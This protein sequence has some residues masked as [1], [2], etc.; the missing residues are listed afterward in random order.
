M[1][2]AVPDL[3][4]IERG[5]THSENDFWWALREKLPDDYYV[6][7][8][9][10]F[11]T[12]DAVQGE[13]DF[14]VF[15]RTLGMLNIECKGKGVFRD[16]N[17]QWVR[18]NPSGKLTRLTKTPTE[19]A[20]G[21]IQG[22]VDRLSGEARRLLGDFDGRF[23]M[24]FGWALAFPYAREDE[25][26]LPPGL[27]PEIVFD[28]RDVEKLAERVREAYDFYGK[29]HRRWAS[30]FSQEKLDRF[31]WDGILR[32]FT[33]EETFA[34]K[35]DYERQRFVTL[36]EDQGEAIRGLLGNR[37][38]AV[39]G[40]AGTGKT[41]L[42]MHAARLLA[43]RG[44]NV[45]VTCFNSGLADH[46]KKVRQRWGELDGEVYVDNFHAICVEAAGAKN[47]DFPD[48]NASQETH[49]KFWAEEAPFA[50]LQALTDGTYDRG[51]WDAI[52]VDEA[53]DFY[54][55]WWSILRTGLKEGGRVAI[56]YDSRQSI[57]EHGSP[58]PT[59]GMFRL[60]LDVN[61]RNTR[62]ICEVV[63]ELG[64]VDLRPHRDCPPGEVP[65]V[66]EQPGPSKMRRKVGELLDHL[67]DTGRCTPRQIAILSPRSPGNS[68]LKAAEQ[69]GD[70]SIVHDTPGW[71]SGDGILHSSISGFKGMEADVI[72]LI[73]IDP[74]NER[75]T[76]DYRYVA[77]SR[78]RHRLHVFQKGNWRQMQ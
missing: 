72:I 74:D 71:M 13:V 52:V 51:P 5:G 62:A 1:A 77:A 27:Q 16:H 60:D 19:Q 55:E 25:L 14:L 24:V 37:K 3:P 56:F 33:G 4:P 7:Y 53:Q 42:A 36:S 30:E 57:F 69:L 76:A 18:T 64:R 43:E 39:S 11:L 47:L 28:S 22:I 65:S 67:I 23:P 29:R 73:D 70:Q 32:P 75:C 40:G 54:H 41:I 20:M 49:R 50:L 6:L 78:A 59:D 17:G 8:G 35:L 2:I 46:L 68:S 34:G 26:N 12:R 63:N 48:H 31:V 44:E 15:H 10:P 21:Q 58:V 38:L 66:Y 61:Y 9:L 45:L